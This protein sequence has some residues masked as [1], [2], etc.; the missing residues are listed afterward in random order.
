[1]TEFI[2]D[3][4]CHRVESTPF[5]HPFIGQFADVN[6][7]WRNVHV[8]NLRCQARRISHLN[9]LSDDLRCVLMQIQDLANR[10]VN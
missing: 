8:V 9:R 3:K 1:M 7:R 2:C 10:L 6:L 5:V 4:I